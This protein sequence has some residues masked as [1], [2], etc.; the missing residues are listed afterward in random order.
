MIRHLMSTVLDVTAA[1]VRYRTVVMKNHVEPVAPILG[2][3]LR[4]EGR[5][6]GSRVVRYQETDSPDWQLTVETI[7]RPPLY[8]TM[9]APKILHCTA[10]H[11]TF[12]TYRT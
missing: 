11:C 9:D 7:G 4:T 10:R 12:R 3:G 1:T 6:F 2:R 5:P 8:R